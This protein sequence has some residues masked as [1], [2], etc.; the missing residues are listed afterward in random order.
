MNNKNSVAIIGMSGLFPEAPG[1]ETFYSNLCEGKD[2][3]RAL[4]ELRIDTST[5]DASK[6]Y[7][8]V[9]YLERV[10]LFDHAFFGI[11]RREA[12]LMEP[13][14]RLLLELS[15]SAIEN[16]GYGLDQFNG[17]GTGV[18][19]GVR[20]FSSYHT[21]IE[22]NDPVAVTGNLNPMAAGRISYHLNLQG[23][24]MVIDTACSSSLVAVHEACKSILAGECDT[25]IAGAVR[26]QT[27]FIES[28]MED[29]LGINSHDG[30]TRA[31]DAD[32]SGTGSG[33]GGG[34]ILLKRLDKA[35][36]DKDRIHAVIIGSALNQDGSRSNGITAPSP[37]AQ[38]EVICKA[39]EK[40]HI[41][42]ET[43]SYI[44][45]HGTGTRLGDPI[46]VQ[47]ITKAFA[48]Y[49]NKKGFCALGAIKTNIG[50]LDNAA[51]IAGLTKAVLSLKYKQLFPAVH[52]SKPNP[53]I[54]FENAP[55]YVNKSL[56]DWHTGDTRRRCGVSSF[57]LSGTN[58]HIVLEEAPPLPVA[59]ES[60]QQLL[61]KISAKTPAAFAKYLE[62]LHHHFSTQDVNVHDSCYTLNTG[63]SDYNYRYCITAT[64]RKDIVAALA[65]L[66]DRDFTAAEYKKRAVVA[67]FSGAPLPLT[68]HEAL[69]TAYSVYREAARLTKE[70]ISSSTPFFYE[71]LCQYALYQQMQ[72]TGIALK[73]IIG[74]GVGAVVNRVVTGELAWE[75]VSQELSRLS[76]NAIDETKLADA[77]R[78]LTLTEEV[79]FIETGISGTLSD[80][81][82]KVAA[83]NSKAHVIS[84]IRMDNDQP[85]FQLDQLY[86]L[87]IS[88]NW[89]SFYSDFNYSKTDAPTYPFE[90]IRCWCRES[91]GQVKDW[92]YETT[93]Q[94]S[95]DLDYVSPVAGKRF[96]L[97]MD[98]DHHGRHLAEELE[99]SGNTVIR[100]YNSDGPGVNDSASFMVDL[101]DAAALTGLRESVGHI[102]GIVNLLSFAKAGMADSNVDSFAVARCFATFFSSNHFT[103]ISVVANGNNVV[104]D[105]QA[106]EPYHHASH[107]FQKALLTEYPLLSLLSIDLDYKEGLQASTP[108]IMKE[109]SGDSR[110]RFVA[111]RKK[112]RYLPVIQK[113]SFD[114]QALLRQAAVVKGG[115]YVITGGASGIGLAVSM[116]LAEQGAG[117]LIIIGRTALTNGQP[118]VKAPERKKAIARLE[119]LGVRVDYYAADVADKKAM[120][121]VFA[122]VKSEFESIDGVI[123]CAVASVEFRP[124]TD[125]D[126]QLFNESMRVKV[127]GT[128]ILDE[129]TKALNPAFFVLFS[130]LNAHVPHRNSTDYAVANAFMEGYAHKKRADGKNFIAVAW[131]GWNEVGQSAGV[132]DNGPLKKINVR[133]GL[134]ALAYAI[135]LQRPAVEVANINLALFASNP[136]FFVASDNKQAQAPQLSAHQEKSSA[137]Q[138]DDVTGSI[139]AVWKEVLM[140]DKVD[141]NDDFFE[142]GGHSLNGAQVLNRINKMYNLKLELDDLFDNGTVE[143]LS[144]RVHKLLSDAQPV[145]EASNGII[146][147][148][149]REHYSLSHSQKRIWIMSQKEDGNVAYNL[150]LAFIL[151]G[152][153]DSHA[154]GKAFDGLI[155]RHESLRTVFT[156]VSG[157]PVQK[158]LSPGAYRFSLET[159]D[160]SNVQ[161]NNEK[162]AEI[163]AMERMVP[164]DLENGPLIRVILIHLGEEHHVLFYN[165]HH[166]VCDGWSMSIIFDEVLT[167]YGMYAGVNSGTLPQLKFQ[168][169]DYA[170]W[171]HNRVSSGM[172]SADKEYWLKKLGGQLPVLD[173]PLDMPRPRTQS[174]DG[175]VI[176][177]TLEQ[178]LSDSLRQMARNQGS[179]LFM[180]MLA[181]FKSLLHNYTGQNDILVGTDL[182]G[183]VHADTEGMIGMFINAV[184]LRTSPL[185]SKPFHDFLAEVKSTFLEALAHQQYQFDSIVADVVKERDLSRNP[186]FDVMF[187]M[188]NNN[189]GKVN[190][191]HVGFE[192]EHFGKQ[193]IKSQFDFSLVAVDLPDQLSYFVKFNTNLFRRSSME[194]F[195]EQFKHILM[196]IAGRPDITLGE[197]RNSFTL[198]AKEIAKQKQQSMRNRN[199]ES[200]KK[201]GN[202]N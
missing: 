51:G 146:S 179:T 75:N 168:Y 137:Q 140:A 114:E 83:E 68:A 120:E 145:A 135:G 190:S 119:E 94:K 27:E 138:Q 85:F 136:F 158:I 154:F 71:F 151:K 72:S 129:V 189:Q 14:H 116:E 25:A 164:F 142:I 78:A 2:S 123:H 59:E 89:N 7:H 166:I 143:Q 141:V 44:E 131:P 193:P 74:T 86:R 97:F 108:E 104:N 23:P 33:E 192:I 30:K 188:Q 172:I 84:F 118:D 24:A 16:A 199:L 82:R 111:F 103:W 93:W 96:L 13:S 35:I 178:D 63:R 46:E 91:S 175:D 174:F 32:S 152:K 153:I 101:G 31:F 176:D 167:L 88:L 133:D 99:R 149:I 5:L 186:L 159:I 3:V 132:A 45:A 134:R 200:L 26:V 185:P 191:Q 126:R 8:V 113:L 73:M 173:M 161:G 18:Y 21:M 95:E 19:I 47:G 144:E 87:G 60:K 109:I 201:A 102:D 170:E 157:E 110:I 43:I 117:H 54:D 69:T 107:A 53:F 55:V 28:S 130:S 1:L 57:G 37:A 48:R 22:G 17:S 9:G 70:H 20:S 163:V 112:A 79:V 147:A 58:A 202:N 10:D 124:L 115:V 61:L 100:V 76:V 12:G 40:A 42:P 195:G 160:I 197:I 41:D 171:Q 39:W 183:R 127:N 122:D 52:F 92:I 80:C 156:V 6:S 98:S 177:F 148:P 15:V 62:K 184:V 67:F 65:E 64:D 150:P 56:K 77:I 36:E 66:I 128:I 180:V 165:I 196:L 182:A 155:E 121:E 11:S 169:K 29:N 49:T 162:A 90:E 139:L 181:A 106:P 187:V 50:H 194:V 38:E 105:D 4:S 125:L 81:A 34:V 198:Y